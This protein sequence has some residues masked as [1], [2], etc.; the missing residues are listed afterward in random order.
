MT[1]TARLALTRTLTEGLDALTLAC[2]PL[3][4][5]VVPSAGMV[6]ASLVHEGEEL[7]GVRDGVRAYAATGA[8]MGIPLLHPWANRL[9]GDE[10]TVA[11]RR[12]RAGRR[13]PRDPAGLPI[14]GVL[15]RPWKVRLVGT[16]DD[17]VDVVAATRFADPAFPFP[18]DIEQR[19]ALDAR[20]LRIATTLRG[21]PVPIAFGFH[22]YLRL[23]GVARADWVAELPAR[24]RLV[25]D[26]RM[27]PTGTSVAEPAER[28]ALGA[29][30]FDDGYERLAEP[31]FAVSGGG[32]RIEVGLLRG[33]THAQVYAPA[34]DHVL[35]FEPMTAP[36]NALATGDGLRIRTSF[37]AVFEIRVGPS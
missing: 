31:H 8:T 29:R 32:R 7:L 34:D 12:I 23:P 6:C 20:R 36:T 17:R 4:A 37:R 33:Y 11:G 24:R 14:H 9:A 26:E 1:I 27:L 5:T 10:V 18:H 22:P 28:R 25:A 16:R 13:T 15:P 2:G 21:G 30:T 35:C 3:S 19:V